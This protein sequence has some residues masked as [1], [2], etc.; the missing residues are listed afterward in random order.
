MCGR[1]DL[2]DGTA[3]DRLRQCE[4]GPFDVKLHKIHGQFTYNSVR[5]DGPFRLK[6]AQK[7]IAG[8]TLLLSPHHS[9]SIVSIWSN[10]LSFYKSFMYFASVIKRND[11]DIPHFLYIYNWHNSRYMHSNLVAGCCRCCR[12]CYSCCCF[13]F[14]RLM[15]VLLVVLCVSF[16]VHNS[17]RRQWAQV[18]CWLCLTTYKS[19]R[20]VLELVT[21]VGKQRRQNRHK[22]L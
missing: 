7:K 22:L 2:F 19:N 20:M 3:A 6:K 13:C 14:G 11:I 9:R 17:I 12:C 5:Q 18:D 15:D 1:A 21:P 16:D 4:I 10:L 8:P